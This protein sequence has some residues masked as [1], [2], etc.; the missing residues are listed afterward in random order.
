MR[1][2]IVIDDALLKQAIQATGL[3]TQCRSTT[4]EGLRCHRGK[5]CQWCVSRVSVGRN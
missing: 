3:I 5:V 1:T 2:N 4:C